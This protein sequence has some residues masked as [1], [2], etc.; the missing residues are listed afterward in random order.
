[1]NSIR[2]SAGLRIYTLMLC[3]GIPLAIA[4]SVLGN[5]RRKSMTTLG[6]KIAGDKN[7]S[8]HRRYCSKNIA[9]EVD[10]PPAFP[11]FNWYVPS[12]QLVTMG[13]SYHAPPLRRLS[14][15]VFDWRMPF[16]G[17]KSLVEICSRDPSEALHREEKSEQK[18]ISSSVCG[19]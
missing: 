3:L 7:F 8:Q 9:S 10:T 2:L 6:K 19:M 11:S 15:M 16:A 5:T 4:F 1:M 14:E 18:H 12:I 13:T 17:C